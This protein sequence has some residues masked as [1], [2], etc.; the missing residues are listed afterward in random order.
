MPLL[1]QNEDRIAA[2]VSGMEAF[3]GKLVASASTRAADA[4]AAH[5]SEVLIG[6]ATALSAAAAASTKPEEDDEED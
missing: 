6:T 2:A 1:R 4:V 5:S 3:L